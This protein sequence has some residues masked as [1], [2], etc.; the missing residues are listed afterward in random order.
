MKVSIIVTN[1]NYGKYISK[2]LDSLLSQNFSKQ[3]YEVILIDD[4]SKDNSLKIANEFLFFKNFK[5]L[6]NSKNLGVAAS[7]NKG[8]KHAKG[9]FF[10]R[11]D[12]DDYVNKNFIKDLYNKINKKKKILGISC[13]YILVSNSGKKI[14]K[15]DYKK[16]PIS[17]GVMYNRKKLINLGIYNKN[18][19][20]RE[21]EELRK[22]LGSFYNIYNLKKY[23]YFYRMHNSN[24]T[25]KKKL[26][27]NFKLKLSKLYN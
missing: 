6:K 16:K 7:S 19:K 17:C 4:Y 5:I 12:S 24:K 25:K 1:Y 23:L 15:I 21:E 20:H 3:N 18:F 2:C 26:M 11:V 22:R 13:N 8:I 27:K 9:N 10:V 14:K